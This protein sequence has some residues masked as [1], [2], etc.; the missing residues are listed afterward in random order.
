MPK[1]FEL[2]VFDWDGTLANSAQTIVSAIQA[3]CQDAGLPVPDEESSRGVIG[4]G[5]REAVQ[6]LFPDIDETIRQQ[7]T[8]GYRHYYFE[9]EHEIS[10]FDGVE[11]ALQQFANAGFLLAVATGKGRGGLDREMQKTGLYRFIHASRCVDE[12]FSKPHPQMLEQLMDEL[13]VQPEQTVMIGDTHYDLQMAQNA[14]VAGL[15]VSYGAQAEASLQSHAPLACFDSF[16][17]LHAWL[18]ENA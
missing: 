11:A 12:C 9:N 13:G 5:L 7:V 18:N 6:A 14:R 4:L 1:K 10:L 16:A 8:Q 2:L 3:A 17:K 15:G